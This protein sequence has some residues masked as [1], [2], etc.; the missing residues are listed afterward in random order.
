MSGYLLPVSQQYFD[1]DGAPLTAGSIYTYVAG[2]S[3]PKSTYT[4]SALS[5]ANAN[6]TVLDAAGRTTMFGTGAYKIVVKD[7][8]GVTISTTDNVFLMTR[9]TSAPAAITD[10]GTNGD[11]FAND[12]YLYVYGATGWRRVAVSSF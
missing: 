12:S 2:T 6:P 11:Y 5:V 8:D 4:T 9:T 7:A 1:D 3:T 10:P